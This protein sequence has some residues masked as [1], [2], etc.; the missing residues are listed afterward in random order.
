M[1]NAGLTTM[2][3][4]GMANKADR[5]RGGIEQLGAGPF[6]GNNQTKQ[7]DRL[8]TF[9]KLNVT[10]R[11]IQRPLGSGNHARSVTTC[12]RLTSVWTL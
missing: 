3:E 9:S 5:F 8:E 6:N 11:E 4:M 10:P 1:P 2:E 12:S 7:F